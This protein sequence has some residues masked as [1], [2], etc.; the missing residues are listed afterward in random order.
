[1]LSNPALLV[2]PP[3]ERKF[4]AEPLKFD[5]KRLRVKVRISKIS[6]PVPREVL[7][8]E[9]ELSPVAV[10]KGCTGTNFALTADAAAALHRVIDSR[11]L[12]G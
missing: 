9:P 10:F 2:G 3:D 1:V 7:L 8:K 12:P 11:R 6:P 5:G 4:E